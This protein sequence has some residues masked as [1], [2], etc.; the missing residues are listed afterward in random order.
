MSLKISQK[1]VKWVW[2]LGQYL[3]QIRSNVGEK[4]PKKL[5]LSMGFFPI[6]HEEYIS[7]QGVVVMEISKWRLKP[8]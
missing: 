8:K 3:G 6:L 2:S 7:K 1:K 5:A 4:N